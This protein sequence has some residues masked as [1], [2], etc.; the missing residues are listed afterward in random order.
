MNKV[1]QILS[2]YKRSYFS[3]TK[4]AIYFENEPVFISKSNIYASEGIAKRKIADACGARRNPQIRKD[5]KEEIEDLIKEN[6]LEIRK[7]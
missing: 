4:Y 5:I 1:E 3:K 7:V 6:K 2:G